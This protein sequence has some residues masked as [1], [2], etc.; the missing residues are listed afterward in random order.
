MKKIFA[1]FLIVIIVFSGCSGKSRRNENTQSDDR[2][3][4]RAVWIFYSELSMIN[5]QGGT[6]ETFTAKISD[7]FDECARLDLNHVFVQVR[8]FADSFYPSDIFPWSKYLTGEQGKAVNYDPLKIMVG[9]AHERSL[10][11]HAW[12]NPFRISLSSSVCDTHPAKKWI[13]EKSGNVIITDQGVFF[14]P[15]SVSANR[16]ILD[17]IREIARNYDVDGIHIDDY[18]YMS[19]SEDIDKTDYQEYCSSGGKL[20][21]A[22][23]RRQNISFFVSSMYSAVKAVDENII[24]SVSPAGNIDNNYSALYADVKKWAGEKGYCD[25]LMPQ[26][27]Y[28]FENE[29]LPYAKAADDW[30]KIHKEKSIKLIAGLA[31]YRTVDDPEGEWKSGDIIARQADYARN[32]GYDGY[33]LFSYSSVTD[34]DFDKNLESMKSFADNS[35]E[36]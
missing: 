26:L 33:C 10:K 25:W 12:I 4:I 20:S 9:L 18:F 19:Q 8:P 27:Y 32:K 35:A 22:D 5:E 23:W 34:K 17:G 31:A 28:G 29:R 21:L 36:K 6:E 13:E 16:L 15:A 1:L 11:I 24:V 30:R 3:E 7:M 14:N 2:D